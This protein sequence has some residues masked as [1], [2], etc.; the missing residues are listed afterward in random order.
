MSGEI[1]TH[2][3]NHF[4]KNADLDTEN[5]INVCVFY[6]VYILQNI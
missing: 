4:P 2:F 6:I 5:I 1:H 3:Y